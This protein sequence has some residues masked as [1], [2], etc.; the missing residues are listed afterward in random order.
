MITNYNDYD[1]KLQLQKKDNIH[2]LRRILNVC[3]SVIK[4]DNYGQLC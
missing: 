1:I 2:V 3:I 4:K